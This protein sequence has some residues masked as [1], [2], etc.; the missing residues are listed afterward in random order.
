[1]DSPEVANQL[2][3]LTAEVQGMKDRVS[4]FI[5]VS[6]KQEAR[7]QSLEL[8]RASAKG[9]IAG[10]RWLTAVTFTLATALGADRIVRLLSG[11]I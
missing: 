3:R 5:D 9:T 2:G 7:I 6:K 8:S 4:D 1:M 10:F 11:H